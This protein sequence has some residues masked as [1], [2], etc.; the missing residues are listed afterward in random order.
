MK[1]KARLGA[2]PWSVNQDRELRGNV[3]MA[4]TRINDAGRSRLLLSAVNIQISHNPLNW[5]H[6]ESRRKMV[7]TSR[8]MNLSNSN[9]ASLEADVD[10]MRG[11]LR[12]YPSA[13]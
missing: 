1:A 2:I 8:T 10:G 7:P 11:R 13:S 4:L 6:D 12:C 9:R 5:P 3:F